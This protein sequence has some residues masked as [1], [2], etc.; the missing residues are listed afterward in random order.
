M[1]VIPVVG[2]DKTPEVELSGKKIRVNISD[3][4]LLG[5]IFTLAHVFGHYVQ[6]QYPQ[7]SQ[8]ILEYA[9]LTPPLLLT[10]AFRDEFFAYE[11]EAYEIGK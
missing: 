9:A 6:M 10:P 1:S 7:K 5:M 8:K 4:S 3:R 11:K 2:D